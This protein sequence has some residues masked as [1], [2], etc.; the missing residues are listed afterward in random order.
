MGYY[1]IQANTTR[2]RKTTATIR[3]KNLN[4]RRGRPN[5]RKKK[6]TEKK[7]I[8]QVIFYF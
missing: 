1:I 3:N 8:C 2:Q 6:K 7:T 4:W 5:R